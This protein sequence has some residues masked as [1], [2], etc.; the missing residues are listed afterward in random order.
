M[1]NVDKL[2]D[3]CLL[4]EKNETNI[5]QHFIIDSIFVKVPKYGR[6]LVKLR[7]VERFISYEGLPYGSYLHTF[8]KVNNHY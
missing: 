7:E 8:I 3:A 5:I 6:H 2:Y 1:A 4:K